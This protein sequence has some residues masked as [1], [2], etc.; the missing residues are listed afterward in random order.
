MSP[1]DSSSHLSP[2]HHR[3]QSNYLSAPASFPGVEL[4]SSASESVQVPGYQQPSSLRISG[5]WPFNSPVQSLG[6]D[7]QSAQAVPISLNPDILSLSLHSNAG[8]VG[9][10]LDPD[11][12]LPSL[13]NEQSFNIVNR[14]GHLTDGS[15]QSVLNALIIHRLVLS[16]AINIWYLTDSFT[17]PRGSYHT[18]CQ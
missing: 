14:E 4:L 16:I 1:R 12:P 6:N 15:L 8:L 9:T 3:C 13:E 2:S 18:L 5:S 7:A 17:E 11:T 10:N